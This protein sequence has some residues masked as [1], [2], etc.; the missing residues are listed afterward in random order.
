MKTINEDIKEVLISEEELAKRVSELGKEITKDYKDGYEDLILIGILKGA[1]VFLADLIK[2]IEIPVQI[3]FMS[4]SSY[5]KGN[6]ESSGVVRILKDLDEDITDKHVLLVEDII[7]S[8]LTLSYLSDIMIRRGAKSVKIATLL[9]KPARRE[10][11]VAIDYCG[12]KVP[13]EFIVGYGI[14]YSEKYRNLTFIGA[15]DE[16]AY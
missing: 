12:F 9:N 3:D 6:T 16:K 5:G 4:V 7:D 10:K 1:V 14:D 8:G 11:E 13:N 2:E 15:L